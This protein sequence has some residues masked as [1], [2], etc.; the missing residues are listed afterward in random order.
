ME[1]EGNGTQDTDGCP[2]DMANQSTPSLNDGTLLISWEEVERIS[3]PQSEVLQSEPTSL[4]LQNNSLDNVVFCWIDFSG[5]LQHFRRVPTADTLVECTR[6][7]HAFV[8]LRSSFDASN[9]PTHISSIT[10]DVC[11]QYAIFRIFNANNFYVDISAL[12]QASCCWQSCP[13]HQLV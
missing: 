5:Q 6:Q 8:C 11:T 7:G 3:I 9:Q 12:L 1:N 10:S 4:T 2:I 13:H